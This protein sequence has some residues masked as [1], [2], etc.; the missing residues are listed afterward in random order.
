MEEEN[1]YYVITHLLEAQILYFKKLFYTL[2]LVKRNCIVV[3]YC[4]RLPGGMVCN[5]ALGP[6]QTRDFSS[7]SALR[8]IEN[9]CSE[10]C[11]LDHMCLFRNGHDVD[12]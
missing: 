9:V 10:N 1:P 5:Q 8:V 11:V 3:Q 6:G 12:M 4:V 2:C 7:L